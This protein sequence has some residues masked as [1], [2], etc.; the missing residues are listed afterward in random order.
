MKKLTILLGVVGAIAPLAHA[1][2]QLSW[3]VTTPVVCASAGGSPNTNA[4]CA[5][6][7]NVNGSGVLVTSYGST[8]IQSSANSQQLT[9]T[10]A[11]QNTSGT[12]QTLTLWAV[13]QDFTSP[14]APPTITWQSN[15]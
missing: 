13:D 1:N 9:S 15:L 8:G 2:L 6:T 5:G 11:I 3:A 10:V 4:L 12:T 14:T 7:F